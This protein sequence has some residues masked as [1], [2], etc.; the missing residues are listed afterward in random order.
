MRAFGE[1]AH[2][3]RVQEIIEHRQRLVHGHAADIEFRLGRGLQLTHLAR[4]D[5][6]FAAFCVSFSSRYTSSGFAVICMMPA[7]S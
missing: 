3:G 2:I 5:P 4:D 6:F 7:R 1:I